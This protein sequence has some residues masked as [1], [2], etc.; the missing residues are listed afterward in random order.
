MLNVEAKWG[1]KKYTSEYSEKK[2]KKID[3]Q[4]IWFLIPRF[5]LLFKKWVDFFWLILVD[6][7]SYHHIIRHL[8]IG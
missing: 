1:W 7:K 3:E 6:E 8:S 4:W 5:N 2:I